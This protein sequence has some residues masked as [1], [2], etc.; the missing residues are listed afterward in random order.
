MMKT[1]NIYIL[2]LAVLSFQLIQAQCYE[3]R[4]S[5]NWYDGWVSC[6]ISQNPIASYGETHWIMY[7]LGYEYTLKETKFWNA[8]EPKNL[9][10]GINA[11]NLDYSLDGVTWTNLGEFN[12]EQAS[13]LSTYEGHVGPDFDSAEARYILITPNSNY[14]GNCYGL[15]EMKISLEDPFLD[16]EE[17]DVFNVAIYPNPFIE[18]ISLRIATLDQSAPLK[19]TL[20]DILGRSIIENSLT[21]TDGNGI[22]QIA[23][24]GK[25]L[26]FGVYILKVIQNGKEQSF[27]LIK[28]E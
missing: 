7:D 11:F 28:R 1:Q 5:T 6:E 15:S 27:K 26:S 18:N 3:D 19:Y 13:G 23:L 4:H 21:M 12:M 20:Y 24:N 2:V 22:Y 16:I 9:N 25:N 14:G 10:Y 8:N 17:E